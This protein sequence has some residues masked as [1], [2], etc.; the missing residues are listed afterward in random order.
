[1]SDIPPVGAGSAVGLALLEEAQQSRREGKTARDMAYTEAVT[2]K[3]IEQIFTAFQHSAD[4]YAAQM[5][6]LNIAV[7]TASTAIS[8]GGAVGAIGGAS[9]AGAGTANTGA[10]T[11]PAAGAEGSEASSAAQTSG[12][13][14]SQVQAQGQQQAHEAAEDTRAEGEGK[15]QKG[16][17]LKDLLDGV[18]K[19][20]ATEKDR[21]KSTDD[22]AKAWADAMKHTSD[23]AFKSSSEIRQQNQRDAEDVRLMFKIGAVFRGG[24][25]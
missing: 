18:D 19:V 11:G 23:A 2:Q 24:P 20:I 8:V 15:A 3:K 13:A 16:P 17:G 9:P 14:A 25:V 4:K 7:T 1:M 22:N 21:M 6:Y 12:D 5:A 10:S